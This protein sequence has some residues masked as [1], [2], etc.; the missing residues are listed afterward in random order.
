MGT[1]TITI[2]VCDRCGTE[3]DMADYTKGA[4]WG[5]LSLEWKGDRGGRTHDGAAAG[6][7]LAGKVWLCLKCTNQ[8]CDFMRNAAVSP[9]T[10]LATQAENKTGGTT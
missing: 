5:Q 1:R 7:N 2:N 10:S 9:T 8:F 6:T 4:S 3:Q